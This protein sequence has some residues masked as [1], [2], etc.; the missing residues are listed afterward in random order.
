[1]HSF[2]AGAGGFVFELDHSQGGYGVTSFISSPQRLTVTAHGVLLLAKC[3]LL[4]DLDELEIKDKSKQDGLAKALALLQVGW[5][6]LQTLGRLATHIP[7]SLLEVNTIGHILCAFIVYL[8]W[9]HKPR[10]IHEPTVL[11]GDW[12]DSIFAYMY[13]SSR[14]SGN[15]TKDFFKPRSWTTPELQRCVYLDFD[16]NL[17]S[18]HSSDSSQTEY[19]HTANMQTTSE[20]QKESTVVIDWVDSQLSGAF[21]FQPSRHLNSQKTIDRKLKL[22]WTPEPNSDN[23]MLQKTRYRL[24][25]A[26]VHKYPAVKARFNRIDSA[27][28][29]NANDVGTSTYEALIEQLLDHDARNWPSDFLLPGLGGELMGMTLW[30]ATMAYGG[31]HMAAWYEYF[32]TRIEQQLWRFSSVYITCSGLL[33]L[34]MNVFGA[35]SPWASV[36]WDRFITLQA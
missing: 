18:S 2:Y 22:G 25:A 33:W 35:V 26:A 19:I 31:V 6:L 30:F 24:A 5:M 15:G 1:M 17:V 12:V 7:I 4:P 28:S 8:L 16:Q 14:V 36:Y 10:E 32:P 21:E 13:M 9:W 34:L 11:K 23:P 3:G 29:K 27:H 20:P